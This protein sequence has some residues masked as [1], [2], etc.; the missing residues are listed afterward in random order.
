MYAKKTVTGVVN[1]DVVVLELNPLE[2]K[3]AGIN[4][5][6]NDQISISNVGSA[7]AEIFITDGSVTVNPVK[8]TIAAGEELIVNPG[9][10]ATSN[11]RYMYLHNLDNE[12]KALLHLIKLVLPIV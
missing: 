1:P 9:D 10:F 11:C 3:E 7:E 12:F 8:R 5:M 6:P 4:F 2:T